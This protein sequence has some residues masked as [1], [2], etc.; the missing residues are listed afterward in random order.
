MK[1]IYDCKSHLFRTT[2]TSHVLSRYQGFDD[3]KE[4]AMNALTL[5][6]VIATIAALYAVVFVGFY[7]WST[8]ALI[9]PPD[10]PARPSITQPLE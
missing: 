8:Y 4:R 6:A 3:L 5:S 9:F 10:G 1:S 2:K 7:R